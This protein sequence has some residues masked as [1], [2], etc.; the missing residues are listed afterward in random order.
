LLTSKEVLEKTGISRATLNN[1]IGWGIVPK[2]QVLPPQPQDGA[3]PRIGYFPDEI[4]ERIAQVQRLKSEGWSM[5]RIT[6]RFA[7][8]PQPSSQPDS[9]APASRVT[10]TAA[11]HAVQ[12]APN[13]TPRLSIG[14]IEHPA[15]LVNESF[16]VVWS[17]AAARSGALADFQ[18]LTAAADS[19]SVLRYLLQGLSAHDAESR[20]AL[21]RFHL[22]QARER[23]TTLFSLCR[24]VPPEQVG[25]LE[26][27]YQEVGEPEFGLVSHVYL[28]LA[29]EGAPRPVCLYAV[30]FREGTLFVYLPG[31]NGAHRDLVVEDL[32]R[33]RRP[34]LTQVAVLVTDLQNSSRIWSELPPEEYFE[35]I[36]DIWSAADP[37]FRRHH[38]AQG[39]HAGDGMVCYFFPRPDSNYVWNALLAAHEIRAA[40]R[41]VSQAWQARKGWTTELYLNTGLNEGQEWLGSFQSASRTEFTML[42]DTITHAARMSD[43]ARS[44]AVWATKNLV[45]K[46]S[47]DERQRL[48]YGVRRR[49]SEGDEVFVSAVFSDV[50]RLADGGLDD[51]LR[52][53]A[54]LPITE[55][56]EIASPERRAG[57]P[58]GSAPI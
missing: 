57:R 13:A 29:G 53:I 9:P 16:E 43:F 56:V 32:V 47:A 54:R 7:A 3:A 15:Y 39:K 2:P 42:G 37:I 49:N 38:G 8:G 10:P 19:G 5:A 20:R 33:K 31:S 17:N 22:A 26:S 30:Q 23:G 4:V 46:V 34:M 36:N 6:E 41:A 21:L 50:E 44:G 45:G 35:L 1:Y 11:P 55:I 18:N 25:T 40:M 27:L 48:K 28:A 24:Q 52:E 12:A 51:R 14:E 58:T